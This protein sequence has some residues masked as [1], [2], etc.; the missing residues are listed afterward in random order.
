MARNAHSSDVAALN[1]SNAQAAARARLARRACG[2]L[3]AV[4]LVV[5]AA[6]ATAQVRRDDLLVQS[7]VPGAGDEPVSNAELARRLARLER[8]LNDQSLSDFVLQLQQ[9]QQ[10]LQELRGQVE[11]HQY[12]L[13]QVRPG[14]PQLGQSYAERTQSE[15]AAGDDPGAGAEGGIGSGTGT[16]TGEL[17]ASGAQGAEGTAQ[18]QG[19]QA[20][21]GAEDAGAQVPVAPP[22]KT[23]V[24]ALGGGGDAGGTLALPSPETLE[25]GEREAYRDAF[26]L[27]KERDYAGA[28]K[29]FAGMLVRYP[30]GQFADNGVYWLGEIGYVTKDYP[31]ALTHFNRLISDYPGSP[32]LPSAMLKLGYVYSDQQ[33]LKQARSMLEAVVERFPDTTEGRLAQGRLEQMTREGG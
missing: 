5:A 29:A 31:A 24:G 1:P 26:E 27:L 25:G 10:E 7:P 2:L 13:R 23:G 12:H 16:G 33:D 20:A 11:L 9:L 19:Q 30:D 18:A 14:L 21:D 32:K 28:K 3:I 6:A 17:A 22:P 4:A 8:M 15:Q